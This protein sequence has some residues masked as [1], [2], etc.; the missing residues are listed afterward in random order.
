MM[1]AHCCVLEHG[2]CLGKI[3]APLV[4]ARIRSLRESF[5]HVFSQA[6]ML[7]S[8]V[9]HPSG[10]GSG[11][12]WTVWGLL[13]FPQRKKKAALWGRSIVKG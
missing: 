7:E 1:G 4:L 2:A 10:L 13:A 5:R 11:H 8:I 6:P 3:M 9:M 12:P